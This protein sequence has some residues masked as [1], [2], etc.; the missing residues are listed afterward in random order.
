MDSWLPLSAE[1]P[2]MRYVDGRDFANRVAAAGKEESG[3]PTR[4][5]YGANTH[6]EYLHSENGHDGHTNDKRTGNR[7]ASELKSPFQI[8]TKCPH[9]VPTKIRCCARY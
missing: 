8:N 7:L 2:T 9:R 5:D 6:G 4:D 1:G 3:H